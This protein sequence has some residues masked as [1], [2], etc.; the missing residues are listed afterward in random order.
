M[1]NTTE[2]IQIETQHRYNIYVLCVQL[3]QFL[4]VLKICPLK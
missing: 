2:T 3:C 4:W 1:K